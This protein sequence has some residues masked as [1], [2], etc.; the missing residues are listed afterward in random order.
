VTE[1]SGREDFPKALQPDGSKTTLIT[2]EHIRK[3]VEGSRQSPRRRIILPFHKDHSSPLH[4]MLNG[5]Q[6]ESYIQPHRHIAPPKPESVI[7]LQ[8]SIKCFIFTD[9]G[10]VESI[11]ILRAGSSIFGIDSDPGVYHTFIALEKDTVVFEAKPGPY[12]QA[13]DKEYAAWAPAE[14]SPAAQ[15]YLRH[16]YN[17]EKPSTILVS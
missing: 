5:L 16:L 3:V 4:R 7:V 10:T 8:G 17:L 9:D 13:T 1:R 11:Y 6:P 2:G 14:G 15:D 12:S